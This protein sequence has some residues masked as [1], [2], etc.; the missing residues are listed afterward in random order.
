MSRQ[1]T[2]WKRR[3]V[4]RLYENEATSRTPT[5]RLHWH[6]CREI[7]R[8]ALDGWR[9]PWV[10]AHYYTYGLHPTKY[11]AAITAR[12]ARQTWELHSRRVECTRPDTP[13]Q[14]PLLLERA[15]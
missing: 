7:L 4:N 10:A 5:E 12:V 6:F 3:M 13:C 2:A 11:R 14:L 9:D 15:A 1:A 8:R